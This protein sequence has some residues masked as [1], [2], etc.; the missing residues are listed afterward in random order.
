MS[1]SIAARSKL[2]M[3]KLLAAMGILLLGAVYLPIAISGEHEVERLSSLVTIICFVLLF[4]GAKKISAVI[5]SAIV[6]L[7]LYAMGGTHLF[8]SIFLVLFT[9][10][11]LAANELILNRKDP[12]RLA[13]IYGMLP[14]SFGAAYLL[15]ENLVIS[16]VTAIPFVIFTLLSLCVRNKVNRKTSILVLVGG[17]I[18][19]GIVAIAIYM[20]ISGIDFS[21]LRE[22]YIVGRDA[23]LDYILGFGVELNGE[24]IP[25]FTDVSL[26]RELFVSAANSL[27]SVIAVALIVMSFFIYNYQASMLEKFGGHE[28]ITEDVM[29]IRVSAAAAATYLI[30]FVLSITTDSYG[31]MPF[32]SVVCLNIYTILTPALAYA[33][34]AAIK[35]FFKKR[36]M[37]IGF[38]LIFPLFL[39]A[40]TG[41]MF[42]VLSLLGIICIFARSAKEWSEKKD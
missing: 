40:M 23:L 1:A 28:Y 4:V 29:E 6:Y 42:M 41:Y 16:S 24:V 14:V 11:S 10:V 33:G 13:L 18:F 8:G 37:R 36:K 3:N 27:P 2:N 5:P 34:V 31:N 22:A 7:L 25:L 17:F 19:I 35:S 20:L 32:G 26:A 30:A 21:E 9:S 15:T 39:L 38:L 12:W